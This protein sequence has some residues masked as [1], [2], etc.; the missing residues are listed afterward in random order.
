LKRLIVNADDFGMAESV[1]DG[2][3]KGYR[4]GIITSTSFMAGAKASE[5]AATLAR[6][7]PSLGVGVH[8]CLTLVKPV[9]DPAKIKSLAPGGVLPNGPFPLMT[10]LLFGSIKICDVEVE[11]RAQIERTLA[12]GIKPDHIDGHQHVH[13][14]K[15]VFDVALKLAEEY[16]IPAMRYPVGPDVGSMSGSRGLEKKIF[17]GIAR[18]NRSAIENAGIKFPD[19]FFGFAETGNLDA[20]KLLTILEAL[21]DGTSELMCHPGLPSETLA[22]DSWG[23][24]W[25]TELEAVTDKAMQESIKAENIQLIKFSSLI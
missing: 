21:P 11:L 22:E 24:G 8:L 10:R 13:M 1:N 4:E 16:A 6:D 5:H 9:A 19:Y 2:I 12:L 15:R 3:I 14:M 17:E 18:K 23:A 7:N 25:G 20:E